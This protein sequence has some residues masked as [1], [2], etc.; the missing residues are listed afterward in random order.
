MPTIP[1]ITATI[2]I[3]TPIITTVI[4]TMTTTIIKW[5]N[6]ILVPTGSQKS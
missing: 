3:I 5:L 1:T 6:V 2:T 4:I